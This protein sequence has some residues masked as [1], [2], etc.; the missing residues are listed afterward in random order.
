[1]LAVTGW[2]N[3]MSTNLHER[4]IDAAR[5]CNAAAVTRLVAAGANPIP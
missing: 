1:M 4:L 2:P 3:P 5:A